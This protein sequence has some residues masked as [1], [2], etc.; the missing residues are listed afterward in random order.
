LLSQAE[1]DQLISLPKQ[2]VND[3]VWKY[4]GVGEKLVIPLVSVDGTEE[5]SL[6]INRQ[7]IVLTKGTYQMRGRRVIALARLDFGG[8]A[9]Q[10]PDGAVIPCPHLHL[11][12]EDYADK[13]AIPLPKSFTNAEDRKLTLIEFLEFC[14]VVTPP[15]IEYGMFV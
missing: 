2:R 1:A 3:V 7:S 9:H 5:F 12:R 11:Y 10:N 4:T 15:S 8:P 6:D 14:K 13:W